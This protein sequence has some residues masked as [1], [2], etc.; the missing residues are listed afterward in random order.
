[1]LGLSPL[2]VRGLGQVMVR[3]SVRVQPQGV[4]QGAQTHASM[5][6]VCGQ[7]AARTKGHPD[8]RPPGTRVRAFALHVRA[9]APAR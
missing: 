1:M 9:F 5:T 7:K 3:V 2:L 6:G 4:N 8:I